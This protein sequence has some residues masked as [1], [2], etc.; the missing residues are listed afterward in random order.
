MSYPAFVATVEDA[1]LDE[2]DARL[3]VFTI[4]R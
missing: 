2:E 1:F 4:E 3:V